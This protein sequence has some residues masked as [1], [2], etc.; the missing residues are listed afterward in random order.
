MTMTLDALRARR[1]WLLGLLT[2]LLLAS[3]VG[4]V[5]LPCAAM[6]MGGDLESGHDMTGEVS[7]DRSH[8]DH[9]RAHGSVETP[10]HPACPHCAHAE[11]GSG[12]HDAA[13]HAGCGESPAN[14]TNDSRSSPDK[15]DL[16]I[17]IAVASQ[18][19]MAA[20]AADVRTRFNLNGIP[21][22]TPPLFLKHCVFLN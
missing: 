1:R 10:S 3:W 20:R 5:A 19:D 17:A 8:D 14:V 13:V 21:P 6:A 11:D 18:L 4:A 15:P 2:P 9:H 16:G 7:V 22:P 12:M